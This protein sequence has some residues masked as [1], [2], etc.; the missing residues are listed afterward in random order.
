MKNEV[1]FLNKCIEIAKLGK[2][3]VFP[4]PLVGSVIVYNNKIIGEGFHKEYGSDHAE[5]NAINNVKDKSLL[6]EST[7]YVNL[8]PCSHYGKTP[9]CSDFIIKH[10]IPKVVIGCVDTFSEVSGKGIEKMRNAGIDVKVSIL[11]KESRNLNKRFFTFHE[12]KRPFIILK[13]AESK[14]S[15]IAPKNQKEPFW[16]SSKESK[17]LVH[18]W[19]SEEDSILIGRVTAEKD[20]PNL[21][22][23]E[24]IGDNP[25]RIVVDKK[26]ELSNKLY[27]FND[28]A[29]T[30]VFNEIKGE[31]D[32]SNTFIKTSFNNLI[33]NILRELYK[34]GIQSVIVEGGNKTLQSFIDK[35]MWDEARIFTTK[36]QLRSGVK[37][38]AIKGK[39]ISS[40]EIGDDV[41]KII[42]PK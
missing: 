16:M 10:K 11:E 5:V 32:N 33:D 4:N 20:N 31:Y 15:F 7:L 23:R 6:S 9:P 39:I 41:L 37:S 38:P 28:E 42:T 1:F 18:K 13:W 14:D 12:K 19:R 30:I 34:Q 8:E 26:L 3:N 2:P 24:S 22:V 27:I 36:K 17:K 35:N 40:K 29:K 25:I 21:T